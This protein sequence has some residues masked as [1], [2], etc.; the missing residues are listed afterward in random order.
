[1]HLVLLV[2]AL[3]DSGHVGADWNRRSGDVELN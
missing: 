1:M 3:S 2:S